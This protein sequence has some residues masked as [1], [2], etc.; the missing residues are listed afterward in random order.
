MEYIS[1]LVKMG[2][3]CNWSSRRRGVGKWSRISIWSQFSVSSG[4]GFEVWGLTQWIACFWSNVWGRGS[5]EIQSPLVL[6]SLTM[7]QDSMH[8]CVCACAGKVL[9][10][11]F[12]IHICSLNCTEFAFNLPRPLNWL[13]YTPWVPHSAFPALTQNTVSSQQSAS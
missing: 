11:V 3:K 5:T 1:D 8:M 4:T 12:H 2:N 6:W 9:Q 13:H 7:E 10:K